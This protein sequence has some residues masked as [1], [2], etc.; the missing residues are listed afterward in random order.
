VGLSPRGFRHDDRDRVKVDVGAV[1]VYADPGLLE[2]V[3]ANLVDNA[4]RYGG[5]SDVRVDAAPAGDWVTVRVIDTGPGIVEGVENDLFRPFQSLGDR[6][7]SSGAGLGLSVVQGFVAAMGGTV[8]AAGT[9][10][11]GLTMIV[12]LAAPDDEAQG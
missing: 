10:G 6:D 1:A 7:N 4:L 12:E 9:P 5:G 11:G 3:I 8:E 2:R